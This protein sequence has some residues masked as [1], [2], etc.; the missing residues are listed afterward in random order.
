MS[1]K[2]VLAAT[3]ILLA[4]ACGTSP[5]VD[6]TSGVDTPVHDAGP[7]PVEPGAPEL[8]TDGS[9]DAEERLAEYEREDRLPV[10][11]AEGELVGYMN[12]TEYYAGSQDPVFIEVRSY[13]DDSLLGYRLR[14]V[15]FVPLD[16]FGGEGTIAEQVEEL[17]GDRQAD[18]QANLE[19]VNAKLN[20]LTPEE[21]QALLEALAAE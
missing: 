15:G 11:D 19:E 5:Q 10:I 18:A 4:S 6:T 9:A 7:T 1:T 14:F 12:Y 2:T 16:Q 21:L 20:S 17:F 8:V 3:A 13:D